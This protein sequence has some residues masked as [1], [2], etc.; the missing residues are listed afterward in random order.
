[1]IS[2]EAIVRPERIGQVTEALEAAGCGGFYYINVTGQGQQRG[3]EVFVGRG[4]QTVS[5]SSI[6]KTLV[7]TVVADDMK[8]KVVEAIIGAARGVGDGEI[9]DGKIIVTAV[10]DVIRV[11]TGESGDSAI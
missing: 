6:P 8:D 9:G 4:G 5:R 7:R 10:A 2:I 11:R 3:V 1:M